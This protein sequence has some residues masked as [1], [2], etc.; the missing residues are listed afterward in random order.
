MDECGTTR[1]IMEKT[2]KDISKDSGFQ[3]SG[4]SCVVMFFTAGHSH[5]S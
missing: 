5:Y 4:G 2:R 3:P 1:E